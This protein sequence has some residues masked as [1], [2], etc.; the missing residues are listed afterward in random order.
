MSDM[1][2]ELPGQPPRSRL[3]QTV[4]A[5]RFMLMAFAIPALILLFSFFTRGIFP[6]ADRS[7]LT[8]DL[9]HQ[10]APFLAE[11]RRK[12]TSGGSLLYSWGGGLGT[13]F[14]S[15]I[16]YYLAS[17]LNLILV[18]FPAAGLT[19]AVLT[20]VVLKVGLS[21]AFFYQFLRGVWRE[22][23]LTM[24]AFAS[25]Y[26]LSSYHLAYSWNIMWLDSLYL[27]PLVMLGLVQLVR[28]RR[29]LL[30]TASLAMVIAVNYYI[31]FFV[32]LF[33]VLYF[34]VVLADHHQPG[35][36]GRFFASI[37]RFAG[38]SLLAGGLAAVMLVPTYVSLRLT[39]AAGDSFPDKITHYF[40][41]FDY[42]GQHFLL[43]PPT[44]RSG[45]PNMYS[46][47]L[48]LFLV[49][50]YFLSRSVSLRSK[51]AHFALILVLILSFNINSLNFIW[52]GLHFPNQLPYRNSFVYIFLILSL[53]YP[54]L[55][56]LRE[57]TGKQIGAIAA[58]LA[59]LVLLA[60]KLNDEPL[61]I[62]ALYVSLIF[63]VIYAAVLTVDRVSRMSAQD[64]RL[65][66]TLSIAAEL[67]VSTLLTVH[68]IDT[69][70]HYSQRSY[71][72]AGEEPAQIRRE[73]AELADRHDP[74]DFFR[75]ESYGPK[76]TND[77]YLYGYRGLSIFSSTMPTKPVK[78]FQNLGY[79]SNGINSYKYEGS[80]IV[81]DSLFGLRYLIQ[82]SVPTIEMDLWQLDLSTEHID[83]YQNPYALPL[84]YMGQ[85]SL[86]Q[87]TSY[88][89][90]PFSAQNRLMTALAGTEAVFSL[91]GQDQE[92]HTNLTLDPSGSHV[93]KYTRTN[94]GE[95]SLARLVI[96]NDATQHL[97]LYLDVTANQPERGYVLINDVRVDFNA[98]RSTLV[99][100][101]MVQADDEI[102]FHLSFADDAPA[103][104]RFEV[105]AASLNQPVF[106]QAIETLRSRSLQLE[107]WSDTRI[108]GSVTADEEGMLLLT[109]PYDQ[110]WTL[111]VNGEAH[112]YEALDHGLIMVELPAGRHQIELTYRPPWLIRSLL[113]SLVS[114]LV[115]VGLL[116]YTRKRRDRPLAR[117]APVVT[118]P[119]EPEADSQEIISDL[120]EDQPE[121]HPNQQNTD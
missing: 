103:S 78:M 75:M 53:S 86:R 79:H 88:S 42:I 52:H 55:R 56:S 106:E 45:M 29:W 21:G 82:R 9:Y 4:S 65:I 113:I 76:T 112:D 32:C 94:T 68:A 39:S 110:G 66:L 89:T 104:G 51:L 93:Y 35:H 116:L 109:I 62:A 101:G 36:P 99:D 92:V 117:P 25:M 83:I 96:R 90:D 6:I 54:A 114:L 14:W 2:R 71:Y 69:K 59:V 43:M 120:R 119:L 40:D 100:L 34:P 28:D 12:I 72:A 1:P 60:Q 108:R 70:E 15:L 67:L 18:F 85:P 105:Y 49:P 7:L 41:I 38:F 30:Y 50:V 8:V 63:I 107:D 26:A 48:V 20:L 98:R 91:L 16:A 19:E 118:L 10:Y 37:G 81:L 74:N 23:T 27:L 33:T 11:L 121:D 44:I 84:G 17:P 22:Q 13:N 46:G 57:F 97:Y 61:P 3:R 77:P 95:S 5:Q 87:W 80:N 31:A 102:V 115:T 47:L 58:A 111:K 24:V 64:W 73:I